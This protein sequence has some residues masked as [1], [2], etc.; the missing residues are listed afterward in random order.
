MKGQRFTR[1][2]HNLDMVVKHMKQEAGE[3]SHHLSFNGM[4]L[5]TMIFI[6]IIVVAIRLERA[7]KVIGDQ[8]F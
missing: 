3:G 2:L 1:Q 5:E 8:D 6:A 4:D 7:E